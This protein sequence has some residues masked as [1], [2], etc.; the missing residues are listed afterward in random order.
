MATGVGNP[1]AGAE[2]ANPFLA[3]QACLDELGAGPT[4]SKRTL[5]ESHDWDAIAAL[6]LEGW[7]PAQYIV[8]ASFEKRGDLE[9]ALEWYQ[10]CA[11]QD[12]PPAAC[13]LEQL[14]STAASSGPS[15]Q[16]AQGGRLRPLRR[17]LAHLPHL[18][19]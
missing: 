17:L 12:Y 14:K 16:S 5:L 18:A 3:E 9:R 13:K 6:A 19:R 4:P 10:R 11:A 1:L 2:S 8:G 7:A 15:A